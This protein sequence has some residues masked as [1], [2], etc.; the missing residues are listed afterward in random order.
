MGTPP[1]LQ[2][3][4]LGHLGLVASVLG[5]I[6]LAET[7]DHLPGPARATPGASYSMRTFSY[8]LRLEA[9]T[10]P[11]GPMAIAVPSRCVTP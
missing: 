5:R 9:R 7:V 1:N 11:Q 6:R 3:Y 10:S 4:D 2:V 8:L